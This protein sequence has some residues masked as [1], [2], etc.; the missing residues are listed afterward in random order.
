MQT[1]DLLFHGRIFTDTGQHI[2]VQYR[3]GESEL[4]LVIQPAKS[5][6]WRLVDELAGKTEHISDLMHLVN[7]KS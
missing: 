1:V 5:V 2:S 6:R 4:L 7:K 3:I